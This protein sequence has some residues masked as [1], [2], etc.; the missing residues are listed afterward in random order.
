MIQMPDPV[1]AWSN[2]SARAARA[3]GYRPDT[4]PTAGRP[5][6]RLGSLV[7]MTAALVVIVVGLALRPASGPA[8]GPVTAE[9]SDGMFRLELTTP[10]GSYGPGDAIEPVARVT[11][12][13]PDG[14]ITV[15]HARSQ[16]VFRIQE[17]GG[18][19]EMTGGTRSSCESTNLVN[20]EPLVV[21][22]AKSG[23]PDNPSR[24]FD[25]AWYQD[26]VLTLP[27]GTWRITVDMDFSTGGCG[28]EP[29]VL[30]ASN[31]IQVVAQSPDG[32][33]VDTAEDGVFRLELS[34]PRRTY[35]PTDAIEPVATIR[36]L[37]SNGETT[38]YHAA[39]P[40]GFIIEEIGGDRQMGGVMNEPCL[41]TTIRVDT[42][43]TYPFDKAGT[44]ERGFDAAWYQDPVL[45][46][47]VGTWRIRAYLDVSVTDGTATC[48]GLNHY[49]EVQN[50]IT[51]RDPAR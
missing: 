45:R 44:T 16:L 21:P 46:L 32:P 28:D 34:T 15:Q 2:I 31:V 27:V 50:V 14:T 26:P 18:T 17:V 3:T 47:P 13:G 10:H 30:Q 8:G 29:H 20:G 49:L 1:E 24:G 7:G 25:L 39:S 33:V 4:A 6:T 42:P 5:W 12:L 51:V 41:R 23:S 9:A 11:Y 36:Y 43:L 35:A 48:G 38:M 37:G 22:F 40:V 19:R